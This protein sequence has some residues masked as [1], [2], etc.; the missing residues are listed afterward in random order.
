VSWDSIIAA[1]IGGAVMG[2]VG[3]L[4][5]KLLGIKSEMLRRAIMVGAIACGLS[6]G[7]TFV[8]PKLE[9]AL[10]GG[11]IRDAM[12]SVAKTLGNEKLAT[13]FITSTEPLADV[14][15]F[16]RW[17]LLGAAKANSAEPTSLDGLTQKG[18]GR[19][20]AQRLE[21]LFAIREDLAQRS[22][23]LCAKLWTG[24]ATT[25]DVAEPLS[26]LPDQEAL[27]FFRI[28]AEAAQLEVE[29]SPPRFV[30]SQEASR[31]FEAFFEKL[32]LHESAAVLKA[33]DSGS[34][35]TAEDACA[36][37]GI[38]N[39]RVG[40]LSEPTA[41][42]MRRLLLSPWVKQAPEPQH[43]AHILVA[44]CDAGSADA[45]YR[46]GNLTAE[47]SPAV[48][49][50]LEKAAGLWQRAC[51]GGSTMACVSVAKTLLSQGPAQVERGL[52]LLQTACTGAV[53]GGCATLGVA[54]RDGYLLKKNMGEAV[55]LFQ[56]ACDAGDVHGCRMF[57]TAL[58]QGDGVNADQPRAVT[59]FKDCCDFGD[60]RSCA[61][62]GRAN[63]IGQGTAQNLVAAAELFKRACNGGVS[64]ACRGTDIKA[65]NG[66]GK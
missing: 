46:L 53:V 33:L 15:A 10:A 20:S 42:M 32:P 25:Q 43:E 58:F 55:G 9:Y 48:T 14:P 52:A 38:F 19:L 54:Y 8:L 59:L 35:C 63:E 41:D 40:T 28:S 51:D 24:G 62:L 13:L 21:R 4:V 66:A 56:K 26:M 16:R 11:R 6:F 27:E 47:G 65:A 57:A 31:A 34:K 2:G 17:M 30:S 44:D 3:G 45:C 36:A 37:M 23:T 22:A 61:N 64:E 29:D 1:G 39:K 12:R 50:N 60:L 49:A 7:Q 5:P 18:L